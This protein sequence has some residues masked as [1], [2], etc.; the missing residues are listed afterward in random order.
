M[1]EAEDFVR[2]AYQMLLRRSP[3]PDEAERDARR[4]AL[5]EVT[6][7]DYLRSIAQ[8]RTFSAIW[9]PVDDP[10]CSPRPYPAG[11]AVPSAPSSGD[12]DTTDTQPVGLPTFIGAEPVRLIIW[13]LDETFWHG[14]L[15]EG[16]ITLRPDTCA[17]VKELAARG[18]VSS[19]CSK[20]DHDQ[21]KTILQEAEIWQYFVL[22]SI[23][24]APKGARIA[25]LI[26]TIQLRPS[27]VLYIDDNPINLEEARHHVAGIATA[28]HEFI[29]SLLSDP[30]LRGKADP[31]LTRLA[32]Y[33]MLQQ[34]KIDEAN[35]VGDNREFLRASHISVRFDYEV[36][37]NLD[38]AI[39]LI[40]RTNQLNFT[41]L[42]LPEDLETARRDFEKLL[43]SHEVR[44]ALVGVSDKY[45]DH[46]WCGIY[47]LHNNGRL[48]HFAFSC[49][50]LGLGVE[51][52]LYDRLGRPKIDVVGDV[53]VDI[54]REGAAIDWIGTGV[55][56]G[57]ENRRSASLVRRVVARGGCDLM[58]VSH[59][60][61]TIADEVIGEFN[62]HRFGM[63]G[64]IDHSAFLYAAFSGLLNDEAITQ[65]R[66]LGY[67]R[68]DFESA[69]T[70]EQKTPEAWLLS[71]WTDAA[72]VVYRHR[73]HGFVVPFSLNG[74]HGSDARM[75]DLDA[76][77]SGG[78]NQQIMAA[79]SALKSD[80]D[81]LGFIDENSFKTTLR[82]IF[83]AARPLTQVFV[84]GAN[85]YFIDD[86]G[87][88]QIMHL[89]HS[90]NS[91]IA[92]VAMDYPNVTLVNIR[93]FV[94]SEDEVHSPYHFDR[95]VYYRLFEWLRTRLESPGGGPPVQRWAIHAAPDL[96]R[97]LASA[98]SAHALS[99]AAKFLMLQG[100]H[101][102]A[103]RCARKAF[104][105]A[106]R[107]VTHLLAY[108]EAAMAARDFSDLSAVL[109]MI[110]DGEARY[111]A[112]TWHRLGILLMEAGFLE[113]AACVFERAAASEP[114]RLHHLHRLANVY[115]KLGR[116]DDTYAILRTCLDQGDVNQHIMA[117]AVRLLIGFENWREARLLMDDCLKRDGSFGPFREAEALLHRAET[118]LAVD[119][120]AG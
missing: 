58:P 86:D 108:A 38:R 105:L 36:V 27:T 97:A 91:W 79:L 49:R 57:A 60:F 8:S 29:P 70:T 103:L 16:G 78:A 64:R 43:S 107:V 71:F 76:V 117:H 10:E 11:G 106:P 17:I 80:Y 3:E 33:R 67:R 6:A 89:T 19:I 104:E 118:A 42:R 25:A 39:E 22:P 18:I 30:R 20:N 69:L 12:A 40:N 41:K 7:G 62:E 85:E 31:E 24:W 110:E 54:R 119:I 45:G 74:Y 75:A 35:T 55:A 90:H 37:G 2:A 100:R 113:K 99:R 112:G 5:K 96:D 32:Q 59:Y 92:A 102:Q 114:G 28:T 13:D 48:I 109:A 9:R 47:V 46:G 81:Y 34:R 68:E 66:K 115:E 26:E 44:A 77:K 52:W 15:T 94:S 63:D 83:A 72:Y 84:I 61:W 111:S 98:P 14:T 4:L 51:T 82:R 21:V 116:P 23:N 120:R 56:N 65:A 50:I 53:L 93:D 88:G 87:A 95:M 1:R 101:E 73:R